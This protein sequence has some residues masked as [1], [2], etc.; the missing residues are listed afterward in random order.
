MTLLFCDVSRSTELTERLGDASAYA[1]IQRWHNLVHT[2]AIR[3]GGQELELRGDGVLL[4]F[5]S[6]RSGLACAIEIQR[7][8]DARFSGRPGRTLRVRIGMHCG[9]A[10]RV[11]HGYFG[12]AVILSS[13]IADWAGAGE[14][15]VSADLRRR[16]DEQGGFRF[17]H[18]HSLQLKGFASRHRVFSVRWD[19]APTSVALAGMLSERSAAE[20]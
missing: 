2:V 14:I 7:E 6:A 9:C 12:R 20:R 15:L 3:H 17:D 19:A 13:R 5:G 11:E 10:L 1:I 8:I 18:G 4:A 16:L